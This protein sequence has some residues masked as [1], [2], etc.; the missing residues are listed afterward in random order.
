M[1]HIVFAAPGIRRFH[2]HERLHRELRFR[3][4]RVSW[5]CADP[6]AATFA[7]AQSIPVVRLR[8]LARAQTQA[9]IDGLAA[10]ECQRLGLP[11]SGRAHLRTAVRLARLLP[12]ARR[13]F[14]AWTPDLVLLH[15]ERS[16][17][18]RL[19]EFAA[20]ECG[21]QVLWTGDGL[22]PHTLQVD[23]QGLDGESSV[24]RRRVLDYRSIRSDDGLLAAASA[25]LLAR[26]APL[27]L[28][29]RTL[30][31]P[32]VAARLCDAFGALLGGESAFAAMRAWRQ[33]LPA[34]PIDLPRSE[35]PADPFLC[36]LV[37]R[38]DDPRLRLDGAGAPG[39]AD[40]V[41]GLRNAA[42]RLDPALPVVAVLPV[43]GVPERELAQLRDMSGVRLELH[44][45]APEAVA[46]SVATVTVNHPLGIASLLT[47]TPLLHFGAA[48]YQL[49]GVTV[50]TRMDT[51]AA[52]L[53][54]ALKQD[55]PALRGRFLA[56]LLT[57]AHVWCSAEAPDHNGIAGLVQAIE[58]RLHGAAGER[59]S[60][61]AGPAWPLAA[62]SPAP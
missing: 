14:E 50:L 8:P 44:G 37:Q 9:P 3:G 38:D 26:A 53:A 32:A 39:T 49:A 22:L 55:H 54:R 41:R 60:Y 46:M 19:L 34:A 42:Q 35:L 24:L 12:A 62:G 15:G 17:T 59:L 40:L 18:Q 13:F 51:L 16:G 57:E 20:R 48:L 2:L 29:R 6:I 23:E 21:S 52:D 45:A 4:H 31:R 58:Q 10:V 5:L 43:G 47:G 1:G 56:W 30:A 27:P 25:S 28:S 33:A 11:G 61:R 7:M 36:V